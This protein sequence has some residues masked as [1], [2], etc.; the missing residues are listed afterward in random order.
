MGGVMLAHCAL[1]TWICFQMP[2][3]RGSRPWRQE[4]DGQSCRVDCA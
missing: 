2:C 3:D 1:E 4:I